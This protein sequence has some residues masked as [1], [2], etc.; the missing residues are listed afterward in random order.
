MQALCHVLEWYSLAPL[1]V[2]VAMLQCEQP[3]REFIMLKFL[4][5]DG[6]AVMMMEEKKE[7]IQTQ[8]CINYIL[9]INY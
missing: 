3:E 8:L 6:D 4:L 1:V 9:N 5:D 2:N 7:V